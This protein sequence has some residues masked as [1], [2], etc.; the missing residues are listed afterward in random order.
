MEPLL[1]I[2]TMDSCAQS[3]EIHSYP[4]SRHSP[5]L[6]HAKPILNSQQ[7]ALSIV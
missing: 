4:G 5:E 3:L 7:Q 1:V 2:E 6:L